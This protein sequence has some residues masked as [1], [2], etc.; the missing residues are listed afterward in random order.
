FGRG[1]DYHVGF[2][3]SQ[4]SFRLV[5]QFKIDLL[6]AGG[7]QVAVAANE[8]AHDRGADHA[9]VT[10]NVN[11][12]P[13]KIKDLRGHH[14][15]LSQISILKHLD[16]DGRVRFGSRPCPLPPFLRPACQSLPYVASRGWLAPC[17][18]HREAYR[19]RSGGNNAGR[20]QR[21]PCRSPSRS[22]SPRHRDRAR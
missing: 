17:S 1:N 14:T 22:L 8:T 13:G 16:P 18:H 19:L 10:R 7:D 5:L 15:D 21:G 2:G 4:K 3:R 11:S 12:P 20:S 6:A 9:A